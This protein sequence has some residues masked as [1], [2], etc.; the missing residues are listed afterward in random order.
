MTE[1]CEPLLSSYC[2]LHPWSCGEGGCE[3][4]AQGRHRA[5]PEE[6]TVEQGRWP[7]QTRERM[8]YF[9]RELPFPSPGSCPQPNLN[10]HLFVFLTLSP[11]H[12]SH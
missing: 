2:I 3:D 4:R 9:R 1:S 12:N 10:V 8:R 11:R 5:R 6:L 7:C